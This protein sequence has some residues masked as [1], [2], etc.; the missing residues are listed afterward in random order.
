MAKSWPRWRHLNSGI[1]GSK[2]GGGT[3]GVCLVLE[4]WTQYDYAFMAELLS[5]G[6]IDCRVAT[7]SG[8]LGAVGA[9]HG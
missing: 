7:A 5:F 1:H 3:I 9:N 8:K 6:I 4:G 2:Q